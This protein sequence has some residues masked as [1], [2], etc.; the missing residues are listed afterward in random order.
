MAYTKSVTKNVGECVRK[1]I[2]LSAHHATLRNTFY[3][4][5]L[6]VLLVTGS[7]MDGFNQRDLESKN[8]LEYYC[9]FNPLN[10]IRTKSFIDI[11]EQIDNY[12]D[13]FIT[14]VRR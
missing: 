8:H 3:R 1:L 2:L 11:K 14:F 4:V 6:S 13:N 9:Q 7:V 10:S 12:W 5:I